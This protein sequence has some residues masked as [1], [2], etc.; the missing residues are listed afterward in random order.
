M[1]VSRNLKTTIKKEN[2]M[3]KLKLRVIV[4][5]KTKL[6]L[7]KQVPQIRAFFSLKFSHLPYILSKQPVSLYFN[8]FSC[9]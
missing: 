3:R 5:D 2:E 4:P 1:V 6:C 7:T 8:Y 9:Y